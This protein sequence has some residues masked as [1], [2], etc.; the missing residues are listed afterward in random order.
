MKTEIAVTTLSGKA[1]YR[2]VSELKQRNIPFLSLIPGE[3]IPTSIRVVIT[4]DKEKPLV[5]HPSILIYDAEASPSLKIDQTIRLIQ[6]KETYEEVIIGIDPGK[7]FGIAV[8][9]DG[10]VLRKKE[11][12]TLEMTVD[13]VLTELKRNSAHVQKVRI[14][15]G[16]PKLAEEI[17]GRLSI[18]FPDGLRIEMVSEAGTTTLRG[19]G[20]RKK[21]S[22]AD[23]AV[24]IAEKRGN[25]QSGRGDK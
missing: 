18:A 17:A 6:K 23:S 12:L 1:Y 3:S 24:I 25:V 20:F 21:I 15:K 16:I 13:A 2:L 7:T 22:D 19:K 5:K 8:L 9:G 11:G 10:K 4:T 14:G